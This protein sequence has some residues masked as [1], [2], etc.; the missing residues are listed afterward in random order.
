MFDRRQME[1]RRGAI[2]VVA[3]AT[4]VSV[5]VLAEKP[6]FGKVNQVVDASSLLP[7]VTLDSGDAIASHDAG[8]KS[9]AEQ[10]SSL[11]ADHPAGHS[12]WPGD[13]SH[14][15][16][17]MRVNRLRG[18]QVSDEDGRRVGVVEN[19]VVDRRTGHPYILLTIGGF[20]GFGDKHV[21]LPV[22][23]VRMVKGELRFP[24]SRDI[25]RLDQRSR[26]QPWQFIELPR[27]A[28]IAERS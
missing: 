1:I 11:L 21:T 16:Y 15:L 2:A 14:R 26:Y 4:M 23:V 12:Q 8:L 10:N 24:G 19:I 13:Q 3:C 28:V 6:L 22:S 20:M 17:G 25:E 27:D 9:V 7:S 5:A 18:V